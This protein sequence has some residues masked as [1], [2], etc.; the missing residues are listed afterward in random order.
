MFHPQF[1]TQVAT[2]EQTP[3]SEQLI[4]SNYCEIVRHQHQRETT[5]HGLPPDGGIYYSLPAILTTLS[6][7]QT[8][9][10]TQMWGHDK[11]PPCRVSLQN[12]DLS[13]SNR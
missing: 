6:W 12:L 10:H 11:I 3:L 5:T 7:V 13:R 1:G 2:H 9:E 8:T 4:H